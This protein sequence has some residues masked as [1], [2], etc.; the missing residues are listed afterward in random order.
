MLYDLVNF[1]FTFGLAAFFEVTADEGA[2]DVGAPFVGLEGVANAV[3]EL[4]KEY[5]VTKA[6]PLVSI[7]G[8]AVLLAQ[9]RQLHEALVA[10][11]DG[12][13]GLELV[14]VVLTRGPPLLDLLELVPNMDLEVD[15]LHLLALPLTNLSAHPA[16]VVVELFLLLLV[17]LV[18]Q[19]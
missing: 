18:D 5:A 14:L 8:D 3:D 4:V 11:T 9:V 12:V 17:Q 16:E 2:F 15:R 1:L 6:C 7:V 13:A 10:Q 19:V